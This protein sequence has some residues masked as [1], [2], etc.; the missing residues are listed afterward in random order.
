MPSQ[1]G[2]PGLTLT[3]TSRRTVSACAIEAP[4]KNPDREAERAFIPRLPLSARRLIA[5]C[6]SRLPSDNRTS[7]P[8]GIGLEAHETHPSRRHRRLL[9]AVKQRRD[10]GLRGKPVVAGGRGDP[11]ERGV[12]STASYEARRCGIHLAMPLRTVFRQCPEAVFL[13]VDYETYAE[14]SRR[15]KAILRAFSHFVRT[16]GSTRPFSIFRQLRGSSQQIAQAI[17]D[18]ILATSVR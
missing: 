2:K 7:H 17:K 11:T 12:V 6:A 9:W 4:A 16:A 18:R 13:P 15:I 8:S 1:H 10:P 5:A 14:V 3:W